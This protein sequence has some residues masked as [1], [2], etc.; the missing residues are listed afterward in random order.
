VRK[1]TPKEPRRTTDAADLQA[2]VERRIAAVEP[3]VEV[4][5]V[6]L[7]G[8]KGSSA[9]RVYL[10][11]PGGV[12]HEVCARVTGHLRE[13]LRD[14][15]V[16]VSS[17]GPARPLTKP[18]HYRRFLGRRVRIR[19]REALEGRSEFKGE[20]IGVDERGVALAG[21]WGTVTIPH[22]GIRRSNLVPQ[23]PAVARRRR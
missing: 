20:L 18:D 5:L 16:E 11:R 7:V 4:L 22:D 8:A 21:E 10:D 12:D 14:Y 17:P 13:F 23:P 9:L 3:D 19:T 2:E 6:E 1:E 15:T